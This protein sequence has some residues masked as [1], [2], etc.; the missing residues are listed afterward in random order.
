MGL[1]FLLPYAWS[2]NLAAKYGMCALVNTV[3]YVTRYAIRQLPVATLA[4]LLAIASCKWKCMMI[5]PL[6]RSYSNYIDIR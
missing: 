6:F 5:L 1:V 2:K 3:L 4:H